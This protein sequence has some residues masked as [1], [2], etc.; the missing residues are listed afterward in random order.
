MVSLVGYSPLY[1]STLDLLQALRT[2][3]L[4][5]RNDKGGRDHLQAQIEECSE[6]TGTFHR[7]YL[8]LLLNIAD[9]KADEV[10]LQLD[11][12]AHS[13]FETT[14]QFMRD[15]V[16]ILT[17]AINAVDFT[18]VIRSDGVTVQ[19]YWER[20]NSE[21]TDSSARKIM[22]DALRRCRR[23]SIGL[24]ETNTGHFN[25]CQIYVGTARAGD[26]G[27][28]SRECFALNISELLDAKP[29]VAP[30]GRIGTQENPLVSSGSSADILTSTFVLLESV[31]DLNKLAAE[32]GIE[33]IDGVITED[34]KSGREIRVTDEAKFPIGL[35][36]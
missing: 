4:A 15:G 5:A 10:G 31:L 11:S 2:S 18:R 29:S 24:T 7:D 6:L 20:E 1:S 32:N 27:I 14:Q 12:A 30:R 22:V 26:D 28:A 33:L 8:S 3:I 25:V 21:T 23:D 17:R 13:R 16:G 35:F 19:A 9:M 36:G 34:R